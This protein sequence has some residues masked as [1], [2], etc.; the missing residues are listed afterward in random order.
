ML[1]LPR[2]IRHV[3]PKAAGFPVVEDSDP[4]QCHGAW[5]V[6]AI[7][8]SLELNDSCYFRVLRCTTQSMSVIASYHY[9][10]VRPSPQSDTT[11]SSILPLA[12]T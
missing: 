1:R 9:L 11:D 3:L 10:A 8:I 6:F 4:D 5:L 12:G 7:T 2:W